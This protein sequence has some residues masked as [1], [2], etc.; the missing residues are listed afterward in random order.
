MKV[1]QLHT[2]VTLPMQKQLPVSLNRGLCGPHGWSGLNGKAKNPFHAHCESNFKSS[3]MQP[4]H[5]SDRQNNLLTEPSHMIYVYFTH[6]QYIP[7]QNDLPPE[8]YVSSSG[9]ITLLNMV[10]HQNVCI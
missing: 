4:N 9:Y 7:I 6:F 3:S 10:L 1:G 5:Y 8:R 2:P